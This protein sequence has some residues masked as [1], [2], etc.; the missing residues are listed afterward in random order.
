[1]GTAAAEMLIRRLSD[2][3]MPQGSQE[4]EAVDQKRGSLIEKVR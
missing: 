2:P 1:M 4:F 3:E